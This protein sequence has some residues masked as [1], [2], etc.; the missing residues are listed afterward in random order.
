MVSDCSQKDYKQGQIFSI[1]VG[2]STTL[3][4]SEGVLAGPDQ[5]CPV[6]DSSAMIL[7]RS[8]PKRH[9]GLDW[10]GPSCI[11]PAQGCTAMLL[12]AFCDGERCLVHCKMALLSL[13]MLTLH[14]ASCGS[15]RVSCTQFSQSRPLLPPQLVSRLHCSN[16]G[17]ELDKGLIYP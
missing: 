17:R 4:I 3:E 11:T 16:M 5:T 1:S 9:T 2:R 15:F 6:L 14:D 7:S 12:P 10:T 8:S 13:C